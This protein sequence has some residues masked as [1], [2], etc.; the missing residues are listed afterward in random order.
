MP[1]FGVVS[2]DDFSLN[3]EFQ[4]ASIDP[5]TD[6]VVG[7]PAPADGSDPAPTDGGDGGAATQGAA[8]E[9]PP[10]A[11]PPPDTPDPSVGQDTPPD[12]P[13]TDPPLDLG[14]TLV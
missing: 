10:D 13:P 9:P 5:A 4:P 11:P 1:E 14:P 7:G 6:T 12:A 8:T 3:F 2:F